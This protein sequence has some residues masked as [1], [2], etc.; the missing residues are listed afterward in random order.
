M[1]SVAPASQLDKIELNIVDRYCALR[2]A[3]ALEEKLEHRN[4]RLRI[5]GRAFDAK[6]VATTRNRNV[7]LGFDL[8]Q[9]SVERAGDVG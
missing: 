3:C 6:L 5:F 2:L 7:E 1:R 4:G 8:T 9:V